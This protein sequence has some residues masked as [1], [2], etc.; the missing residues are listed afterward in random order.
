MSLLLLLVASSVVREF[1]STARL[2]VYVLLRPFGWAAQVGSLQPIKEI[3]EA[4]RRRGILCHTDAAQ[5][6]GKVPVKVRLTVS[7]SRTPSRPSDGDE[8]VRG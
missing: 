5:S 8:N 3:A 2:R 4:C 6:I 1:V 7:Q